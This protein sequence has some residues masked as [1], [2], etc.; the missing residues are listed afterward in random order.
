MIPARVVG[1]AIATI[2]ADRLEH[3]VYLLVE[4]CSSDGKAVGGII[5]ALDLLGAG[6]GE[7]VLISQGS[8]T[9]QTGDTCDKAVDAL[10]VGII[11]EV[12]EEG[13]VVYQK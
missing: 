7:L 4:P 9:R 3:P 2:R 6:L 12:A 5:V 1:T 8:S 13:K 11:D 10:V